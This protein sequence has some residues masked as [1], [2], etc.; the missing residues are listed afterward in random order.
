[1]QSTV[2]RNLLFDSYRSLYECL[3][4]DQLLKSFDIAFAASFLSQGEARAGT[5]MENWQMAMTKQ[6]RLRTPTHVKYLV[7]Y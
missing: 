4:F 1:M 2:V 5:Q 7:F 6:K 3:K